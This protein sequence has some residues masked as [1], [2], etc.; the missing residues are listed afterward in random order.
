MGEDPKP[1]ADPKPGSFEAKLL[2]CAAPFW[3]AWLW[4]RERLYALKPCRSAILLVLAGLAFLLVA[5]QGEDVARALAE[6][7][8]SD[9][10]SW[11]AFWFFA[12]S[13]AWSL[14]AWYWARVML[15]LRLPG[16]PGDDRS[17]R[18]LRTWTPRLL[19]FFATLGV[20]A[21]FYRASRGYESDEK[22]V[23]ELLEFYAFWC[24]M[25][26]LAFL[27]A[28]S[29][30]RWLAQAA[31]RRV[32]LE[33]LNLRH[34]KEEVYGTLRVR[35]LGVL[36]RVLLVL[37]IASAAVLFGLML[38]KVQEVAPE[39]GSAAILLFAAA[40][41]IAVASTL[42]YMG[43]RLHI[44]VFTALFAVAVL[45]SWWNDNHAVRTLAAAQPEHRG[46]L[47][48]SLNAWIARHDA[49]IQRGD[50]VPLFLV[51][52]EGG[53][54]RAA[55]WTV[56]VLGEIHNRHPEF[57]S[58]VFSVSGVSG[59]S[60]GAG[61]FVAALNDWREAATPFDLKKKAQEVLGA[62]FLSP[63]IGTLLFPDLAQRFLPFPVPAFDRATTLEQAWERSWQRQFPQR[64]RMSEPFDRLWEER[65]DWTPALLLN[66][67]WVETG[68]RIITSN[69]RVGA[70]RRREDFVDVEDANAFFAPRSVSLSTAAHMSARFTYVSPAGSLEKN[71]RTYGRVVDGGYF[72][73]SGATATLAILQTIDDL[74]RKNPRWNQV[75]RFVIHISNDPVEAQYAN[76]S[77]AASLDNPNIAPSDFLNE[78]LSPLWALLNTR[79]ARGYYARETAAWQVTP[80]KYLHFGLCRRSTNVPLGWVLS[81]S[82]RKQMD[83]QLVKGPACGVEGAPAVFDNPEKLA[84]I[85]ALFAAPVLYKET[86]VPVTDRSPGKS[87]PSVRTGNR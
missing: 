19:G 14:S 56:T 58:H 13:L 75:D 32:K 23:K 38:F 41:W 63:V 64:N 17:L 67:T 73:N 55:Y 70:G 54:I 53:G 35:H 40:G 29:A 52:A 85:D 51:D 15:F 20:A 61:V 78:A 46:N 22:E 9:H 27:A 87:T 86:E 65:K 44:P 36:T 68:K 28:V 80:T 57:A 82:A 33:F 79:N 47:R 50:R 43:M 81:Q 3:H 31:Y 49:A 66:A 48:A 42:D 4:V 74:A 10:I 26:A 2:R 8:T 60:L 6:R 76:D 34:E 1:G 69:M 84:K 59:G 18:R 25:G 21:A 62:D 72:E 11:Q 83:E 37:A 30:R 45:F 5:S 24:F 12:A 71:G 39:L 16:V 77:L 7:R